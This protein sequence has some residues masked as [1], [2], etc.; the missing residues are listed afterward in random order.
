MKLIKDKKILLQPYFPFEDFKVA[1]IEDSGIP[2]ELIETILTNE[3]I[4]NSTKKKSE[5]YPNDES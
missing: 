4:W 5:L 2:I 3:E 1:V